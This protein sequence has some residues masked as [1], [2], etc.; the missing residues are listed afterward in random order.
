MSFHQANTSLAFY[1]HA[2]YPKRWPWW[3][4][5]QSM[6]QNIDYCCV[7]SKISI[8]TSGL[9]C[10]DHEKSA[11]FI[12]I[13]IFLAVFLW[14]VCILCPLGYVRFAVHRAVCSTSLDWN[15]VLRR[16]FGAARDLDFPRN[17]WKAGKVAAAPTLMRLCFQRL[18]ITFVWYLRG[19]WE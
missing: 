19:G 2:V 1:T 9:K 10:S 18:R 14:H 8:N 16:G 5:D 6:R 4:S 3:Y 11:E 7:I 15:L 12:N 17:I 13:V